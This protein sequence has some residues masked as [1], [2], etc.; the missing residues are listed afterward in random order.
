MSKKFAVI[1]GIDI[2]NTIVADSQ[3]IAEEATGKICVEFTTEP[4]E[5]GGTFVDGVLRSKCYHAG[6]LWENNRW[7]PPTPMPAEG[8]WI[9][10]NSNEEWVVY[11]S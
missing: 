5:P 8:C 11:T 6:W 1:D 3:E 10:S 2:I 4:A 9:W 7:N